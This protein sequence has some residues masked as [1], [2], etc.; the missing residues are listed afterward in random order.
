MC[1]CVWRE[2]HHSHREDVEFSASL[3]SAAQTDL[4][5]HKVMEEELP[6]HRDRSALIPCFHKNKLGASLP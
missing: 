6:V 2:T 5:Q 1:M 4:T 3:Q